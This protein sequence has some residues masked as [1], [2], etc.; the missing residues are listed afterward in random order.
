MNLK[1]F[2]NDIVIKTFI[3]NALV[4]IYWMIILV[5]AAVTTPVFLIVFVFG[6]IVLSVKF[7]VVDCIVKRKKALDLLKDF[8]KS[9]FSMVSHILYVFFVIMEVIF[10]ISIHSEGD[11]NRNCIIFFIIMLICIIIKK[12]KIE[13]FP[14]YHV[15]VSV[16]FFIVMMFIKFS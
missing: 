5:F 12:L 13:D 4:L 7:V 1:A 16:I 15:F 9:L 6:F 3:S 8:T 11:I 2:L 10:I 14:K